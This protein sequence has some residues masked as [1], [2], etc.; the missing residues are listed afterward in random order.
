MTITFFEV[1]AGESEMAQ[2]FALA[3]HDGQ[4]MS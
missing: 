4:G 2:F 3:N 1:M